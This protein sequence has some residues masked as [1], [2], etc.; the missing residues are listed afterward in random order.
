MSFI[1]SFGADRAAG[2]LPPVEHHEV[3]DPRQQA[4]HDHLHLIA[5]VGGQFRWWSR[6]NV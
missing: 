1:A 6:V 2:F 4:L 3:L 5:L